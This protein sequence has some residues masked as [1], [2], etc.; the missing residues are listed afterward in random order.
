MTSLPQ[1]HG[2]GLAKVVSDVNRGV[3][4]HS[5]DVT[6]GLCVKRLRKRLAVRCLS[7]TVR[8]L[9]MVGR[10]RRTNINLWK[11]R[12]NGEAALSRSVRDSRISTR[13][14]SSVVSKSSARSRRH[15][16]YPPR[17]T[18]RRPP[19][20]GHRNAWPEVRKPT[21]QEAQSSL[22]DWLVEGCSPTH[23]HARRQ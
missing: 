19:V 18:K 4:S 14:G 20:L 15:V 6:F 2:L 1:E 22:A 3:G 10:T 11:R 16:M 12:R 17:V 8:F 9:S 13:K 5:P 23:C 21:T 7:F